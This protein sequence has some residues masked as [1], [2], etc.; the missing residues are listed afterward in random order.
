MQSCWLSSLGCRGCPGRQIGG[1]AHHQ[2]ALL[3]A[4]GHGDHLLGSRSPCRRVGG[5]ESILDEARHQLQLHHSTC[6]R[7]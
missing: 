5:V 6:M 2:V 1:G 3:G 4:E 7:G